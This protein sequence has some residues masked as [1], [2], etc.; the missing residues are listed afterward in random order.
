MSRDAIEDLVHRYADAVVHR[1]VD[2]W[3]ATWAADAVW[4]LGP[5]L[6]AEGRDAI[7]QMWLGAM[8]RFAKVIQTV[9]NGTA[10]L[11]I[12]AGTGT[13]RWYIQEAWWR[14]DGRRGILLAHYDDRYVRVDGEWLF[15]SR[16][17]DVHY[18]GPPDLS[19]DPLGGV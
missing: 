19:A 4:E 10:D 5:D 3:S 9:N 15:A 7:G 8:E 1:D 18:Q 2:R 17:L 6:H 12:D 13:G 11:D 16:L 14:A